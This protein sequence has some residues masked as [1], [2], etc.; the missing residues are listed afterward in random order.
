MTKILDIS[1]SIRNI[2]RE[3]LNV[4]VIRTEILLGL[5]I[6]LIHLHYRLV[7]HIPKVIS[8]ELFLLIQ[9]RVIEYHMFFSDNPMLILVDLVVI[10]SP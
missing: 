3:D 1:Q 7:A 9:S 2:L 4:L 8:L 6:S 5:V 10:I